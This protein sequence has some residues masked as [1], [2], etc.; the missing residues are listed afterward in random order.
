MIPFSRRISRRIPSMRIGTF[1][2]ILHLLI[3][4]LGAGVIT[5]FAL[6]F[7]YKNGEQ[8]NLRGVED[9]AAITQNALD[10]PVRS[11]VSGKGSSADIEAT[12]S[13]YLQ[14]HPEI[15][16]TI[17]SASGEPL[18]PSSSSCSL[19]DISLTSPEVTTAMNE[20]VGHSIRNCPEGVRTIYVATAIKNGANLLGI[21]ILAA[22][23]NDVMAPTYQTMRWMGIIA[24]LIV[25]FTV[26]EGWLG[27]VYISKPLG[28]LS[29][30]AE[31][32]SQ[33][34]LTARAA[35]EGPVE[36]T[37]LAMTLNE[38]AARLQSSLE[39]LRAFVGNASHELRTPLTSIKLQVEALRACACEEPEV[40]DRFLNQLEHEIDRLA[41]TVNDMLDLSQIEGSEPNFQP[42]NL[43]ELVNEVEA[44]W[45]T[46]SRQ[47]GIE[48]AVDTGQH[49]PDLSGNAYQLRRLLDNLLD[50]AIKNTPAGG[51]VKILLRHG[52][53]DSNYPK[54]T[55][56]IEVRDSGK[57]IAQEHIPHIFDRF[58]RIDPHPRG[59]GGGSGLGLAIAQSIV[60]AHGGIIGVKS[61]L[62]AGST[63]WI[64]LPLK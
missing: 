55:I 12:L 64:E 23:F 61:T 42:V 36:V 8:A 11:F 48:L 30:T 63:F 22:P 21:L 56:R 31:K 51:T 35:T 46:R 47:A 60:S 41:Y 54:G 3:G 6:F 14:G 20:P 53:A 27:S 1:I 18:L 16:Y 9:L 19:K 5:S 32:L 17:L 10:E 38:M 58:Y 62:G 33:G 2:G 49:L 26:V 37:H 15:T 44:F 50:N 45:E 57:G 39:S 4:I 24:L 34:D 7:I 52:L 43:G 29:Q 25:A 13:R 28:R 40:A 59:G